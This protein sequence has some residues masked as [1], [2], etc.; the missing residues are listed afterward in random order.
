MRKNWNNLYTL[1]T[2]VACRK[3][4]E[5]FN[6]DKTMAAVE[7]HLVELERHI[8]STQS[9]LRAEITVPYGSEMQGLTT[10]IEWTRVLSAEQGW[11]C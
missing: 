10:L 3:V 2:G 11:Q 7:K 6:A 8:R 4:P 9:R 5:N 1:L